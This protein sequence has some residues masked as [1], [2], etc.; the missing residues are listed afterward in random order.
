MSSKAAAGA[1]VT[2]TTG[3][4]ANRQRAPL[5][6]IVRA[7]SPSKKVIFYFGS[8][9]AAA[10]STQACCSVSNAGSARR[11]WRM[12]IPTIHRSRPCAGFSCGSRGGMC[13]S[14][15]KSATG[16]GCAGPVCS[17]QLVLYPGNNNN[18]NKIAVR[19]SN[20]RLLAPPALPPGQ[21]QL[22]APPQVLGAAQDALCA[23]S[24]DAAFGDALRD[25]RVDRLQ[26]DRRGDWPR[27]GDI[28]A[29]Q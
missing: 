20:M 3:M 24:G 11:A 22:S 6:E 21:R 10:C 19:G 7:W 16:L 17:N 1:A 26:R 15:S 5:H 23:P 8:A 2:F 29:N 12:A 27:G 4:S 14:L 28:E 18:N 25:E 9:C 13:G